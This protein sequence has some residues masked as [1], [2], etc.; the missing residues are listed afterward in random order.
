VGRR[1][2]AMDLIKLADLLPQGVEV[3]FSI[4]IET[5]PDR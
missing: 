2:E 1:S 4:D 3:S 5:V